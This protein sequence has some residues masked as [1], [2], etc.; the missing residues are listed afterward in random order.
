MN[1]YTPKIL[2]TFSENS[3]SVDEKT[4][5]RLS[6]FLTELLRVNEYMNLTAIREPDDAILKNLADCVTCSPYIPEKSRLLDVGSG[7][8]LPA[9][10]IAVCRPDLRVNTVDSTAKKVNF[11]RETAAMLELN[12]VGA[13]CARAETL[14]HDPSFREKFDVVTARA[15]AR[16]NALNELCLPFV[17]DGGIFIAMK[18]RLAD[19][20][21]SEAG[22]SIKVLGGKLE[23]VISFQ[24]LGGEEP[25]ERSLVIIRKIKSTPINYPRQYSQISSKPIF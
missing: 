16:L 15:V 24:L 8:G 25:L 1:N 5:D 18:S 9:L 10:P 3:I 4:A 14:G 21:I 12:N 19:E 22:Q 17:K 6:D 13:I 7:A 23:D 11:I 20:E 2:K